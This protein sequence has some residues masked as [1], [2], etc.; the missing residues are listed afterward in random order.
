MFGR[1]PRNGDVDC[2]RS[3]LAVLDEDAPGE[4]DRLCTDH[5]QQLPVTFT[6]AAGQN[7]DNPPARRAEVIAGG[8]AAAPAGRR[9]LHAV[10]VPC[11]P[12]CGFLHQHK[13]ASGQGGRRTGS[14]GRAY[15]VVIVGR[16]KGAA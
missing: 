5:G 8:F 12:H 15:R 13:S 14:C 11:C 3:G 2:G 6:H 1:G 7:Q 16:R 10:I 9:T 4:L